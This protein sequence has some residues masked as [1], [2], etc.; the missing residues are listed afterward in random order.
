MEAMAFCG[1]RG[2]LFMYSYTKRVKSRIENSA[3]SSPFLIQSMAT[4]KSTGKTV[5]SRK[6]SSTPTAKFVVS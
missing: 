2:A 1:S 6:V 4:Q 5:S 3:I